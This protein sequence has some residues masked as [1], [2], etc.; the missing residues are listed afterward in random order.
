MS[1]LKFFTLS[2]FPYQPR[3]S[4]VLLI[5]AGPPSNFWAV[6]Q[7]DLLE[8]GNPD[9]EARDNFFLCTRVGGA[10]L[11]TPERPDR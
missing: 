4:R 11:P 9:E 10:R 5:V 6:A 8:K 1:G 7:N 3:F 2:G